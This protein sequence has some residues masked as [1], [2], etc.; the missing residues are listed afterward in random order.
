MSALGL[1]ELADR[2]RMEPG[3]W[4]VLVVDEPRID[5]TTEELKE[6]LAFL[7]ED[8]GVGSVRVFAEQLR[9]PMLVD[10][11]ARLGPD[12][13]ALLPLSAERVAPVCRALD[14]GRAR[15]VGGPLGVIVTA[16]AS[17]PVLAA[18]GPSFWSWV[19]P[20]V[21]SLDPE[22]GRLD[23]EARLRSLR[24]GTGLD[25]AEV[26]ARAEAGT[27]APDPIFAEWL[28]LLGRGDLLGH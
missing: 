1:A 4:S 21:W 9:G 19:G 5:A 13:V 27:L 23:K 25:D 11:L 6:E 22:V 15:L 14:F 12:D 28:V 20:R 16:E 10:E 7:L 18:E 2:T 3:G 24:E 26:I 8:E 17:V